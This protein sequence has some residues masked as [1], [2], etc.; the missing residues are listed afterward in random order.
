MSCL[1]ILEVESKITNGLIQSGSLQDTESKNE[2][3]TCFPSHQMG[4]GYASYVELFGAV[5][6]VG[7]NWETRRA[8]CCASFHGNG[9]PYGTIALVR[10]QRRS[11]TEHRIFDALEQTSDYRVVWNVGTS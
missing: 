10:R 6:N 8:V 11:D 3:Q 4:L 7:R 1:S 5:G 9:D 2:M